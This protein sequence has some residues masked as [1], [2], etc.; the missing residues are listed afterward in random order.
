M[1]AGSFL[2]KSNLTAT[3]TLHLNGGILGAT[4]LV[5]F[6]FPYIYMT[7]LGGFSK[8]RWGALSLHASRD[9]QARK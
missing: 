4:N 7:N 1:K 6:D 8:T 9:C 5:D 2:E 3:L